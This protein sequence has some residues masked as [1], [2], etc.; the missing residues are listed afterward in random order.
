[1]PEIDSKVQ[2]KMI[3]ELQECVDLLQDDFNDNLPH[4]MDI[5][6]DM[7]EFLLS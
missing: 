5:I 4:C 3:K 2:D 6:T 1:M 7:A